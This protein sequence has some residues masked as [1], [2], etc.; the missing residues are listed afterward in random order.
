MAK[1]ESVTTSCDT[2]K[3]KLFFYHSILIELNYQ[4]EQIERNKKK[5]TI[6]I[7]IALSLS[8]AQAGVFFL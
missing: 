1:I 6:K 5:K 2:I 7:A 8:I 4:I 3:E